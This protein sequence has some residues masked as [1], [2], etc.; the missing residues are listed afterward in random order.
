MK[1]Y[2]KHLKEYKDVQ[3]HCQRTVFNMMRQLK[4]G[5]VNLLAQSH[6]HS[7]SRA[8]SSLESRFVSTGLRSLH[9]IKLTSFPTFLGTHTY[10]I[11]HVPMSK[12]D[13]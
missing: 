9:L 8:V 6:T 3:N 10:I 12:A 2:N 1:I 11:K 4:F 5:E 7:E 13:A